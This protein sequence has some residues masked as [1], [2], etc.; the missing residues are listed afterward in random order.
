MKKIFVGLTAVGLAL[1]LASC[2]FTLPSGSKGSSHESSSVVVE[3]SSVVV[4]SSSAVVESSSAVVE[5]SSNVVESSSNVVESSSAV[6]E[7]SSAVV[8]NPTVYMVGDSTVCSFNDTTYY[9]PRYGY[10]TQLSNYLSSTVTVS[11][12][13]LSGRSSKSFLLEANYETLTSS[14]STGD[15]LIIGFGHNDEK[16]D[17]EARYTNPTGG[18]DDATSFQ[19]YL[20]TYYIKVAIDAGATP[21]L[22]TPIVRADSSNNYS[23][24][25][26]HVTAT[27]DYAACIKSLGEALNVSVIDLTSQTASLYTT[28]GFNEAINMHAW[29]TS[30]SSS[31]DKTHLNIYGAK[32]VAYMLASSLKE[33]NN[34]L[35]KFVLNDIVAPTKEADLVKNPSYVESSYQAFDAS[36]YEAVSYP[37]F[38][39]PG[40]YGTAFGD[41]GGTPTSAAANGF[42]AQEVSEGVYEVG[43]YKSGSNKG[44]ISSSTEGFVMVFKQVDITNNFTISADFEVL[45]AGNTNQAGF[46]IM[47]RDD[48]YVEQSSQNKSL[49]SNSVTAGLLCSSTSEMQALFYREA[50]KLNNHG[51]KVSGLY[52]QGDTATA[53]ITRVGQSVTT[54]VTYKGVTYTYTYYDFDFTAIDQNYMYVGFIG[55]RG[56][57]VKVT[58]VNFEIT[59]ISQGA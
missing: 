19:Y 11:N 20:Y 21:I 8:E 47:L 48:I 25:S 42:I 4:E 27:G 13:A 16:S 54:S 37:N 50:T 15:Y 17:D 29:T 3:S 44:K 51:N 52:T 35:G 40:W 1:T 7:S 28:L 30:N 45:T 12:L 55:T 14:I 23:G 34:S 22:C 33:S 43:Q 41:T 9:Y 10:G 53:S 5:S 6:V 26:G 46:G 59:G 38:T 31:V 56:T 58:N 32:Q 39:T 36:T 24:S 18:L 49:L 57:S 2:E